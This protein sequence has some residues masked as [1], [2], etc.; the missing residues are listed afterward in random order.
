ME[1]IGRILSSCK[2]SSLTQFVGKWM[3]TQ[4][5]CIMVKKTIADN[6]LLLYSQYDN[7]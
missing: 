3:N 1:E 6:Y 4:E 5:G 7:G 2:T